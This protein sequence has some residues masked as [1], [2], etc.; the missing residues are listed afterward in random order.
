MKRILLLSAALVAA[1]PL[2]AADLSPDKVEDFER[3][4][5]KAQ[6]GYPWAIFYVANSLID[7]IGVEP[8][9]TLAIEWVCRT[10]LGEDYFGIKVLVKANL[11]RIIDEEL[12]PAR[13]ADFPVNT[14]E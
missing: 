2:Y 1:F 14:K 9:P 13:C 3:N 10:G 5:S 12:K 4:L 6:E 11:K 7:G 8:D